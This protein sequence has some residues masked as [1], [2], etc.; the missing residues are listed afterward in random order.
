M[1]FGDCK[2]ESGAVT[3]LALFLAP[4]SPSDAIQAV[5]NAGG[6]HLTAG[7]LADRGCC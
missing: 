5:L 3:L 7:A 4:E 6:V 2:R 1:L